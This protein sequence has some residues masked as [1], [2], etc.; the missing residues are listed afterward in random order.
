MLRVFVTCC[1]AMGLDGSM[2]TA[3]SNNVKASSRLP[4]CC[5]NVAL[6]TFDAAAKNRILVSATRYRVLRGSALYAFL[7][8]S[9]A[10]S[11]IF[12]RIHFIPHLL[13][14]YTLHLI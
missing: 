3:C 13:R 10:H 9:Y 7:Y 1:E 2:L 12:S 8:A 4:A 14:R 5:S 11:F 6:C